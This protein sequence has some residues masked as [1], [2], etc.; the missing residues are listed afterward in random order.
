MRIVFFGTP[1]FSVPS[2]RALHEDA[3]F[4]V[5][6]VVTAADKPAGRGRKLCESKVKQFAIKAGIPVLQPEKLKDA[7][8]L[9]ELYSLEADLYVV[10]AFRMLPEVVWNHPPM[11]TINLHASYLPDYRGAAPINWVIINGETHT[12][13]ST[14][15]LQHEID[16]G[17]LLLR[18]RITL[19]Q[20][21][22]A[23]S[24]HDRLSHAGAPL[25]LETLRAIQT[26]QL[27]EIKQDER[28]FVHSAPKLNR[29]VTQIHWNNNA[30]GIEQLIRGLS[31]FP[32]AFCLIDGKILKVYEAEIGS[33]CAG[34]KPGSVQSDKKNYFQ[35]ATADFWIKLIE[36][37]AEG[38]KRM[39]VKAWLAGLKNVPNQLD[40]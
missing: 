12:G 32:A 17:N 8:F 27:E 33:S 25:I 21:E 10:I 4:D 3:D 6:A 7:Q 39:P 37:Q 19:A 23:G 16:T 5:V 24:L 35:I 9:N 20:K 18:K 22:T 36:I 1:E 15:R 31:P 2:L 30:K 29:E 14:F 26:N 40:G 13:L 28:A 34:I 38:K 11:G